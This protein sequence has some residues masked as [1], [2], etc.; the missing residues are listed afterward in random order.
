MYRDDSSGSDDGEVVTFIVG[1]EPS[2]LRLS[3]IPTPTTVSSPM[4]HP[5]T[6]SSL[7]SLAAQNSSYPMSPSTNERFVFFII[8]NILFIILRRKMMY[9]NSLHSVQDDNARPSPL[10]MIQDKIVPLPRTKK[11]PATSQTSL[12]KNANPPMPP[13]RRVNSHLR[14]VSFFFLCFCFVLFF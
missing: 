4:S 7:T 3:N 11:S 9:D 2:S 10:A 14:F 12:V 8:F 6:H 1:S 5:A 13:P